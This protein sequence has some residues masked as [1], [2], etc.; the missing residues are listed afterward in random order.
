MSRQPSSDSCGFL[1][2][3]ERQ[4]LL[5]TELHKLGP[6]DQPAHLP[7]PYRFITIS[8]DA[9]SLGDQIASELGTRLGWSLYD[10]EI[11]DYIAHHSH[12]R[13]ALVDQMDEHARNRIHD[14]IRRFLQPFGND[15][16][17]VGMLKALVAL[18]AREHAIILGHGGAFAL[19]DQPGLH[20][21]V[22]ASLS[23][24]VG[25][26]ALDWGLPLEETRRRVV[27]VD[28]DRRSFI[29]FHFHED[30]EDTRF[31][32]VIF[33]TDHFAASQVVG[34]IVGIV[35]G[36]VPAETVREKG[37]ETARDDATTRHLA[38]AIAETL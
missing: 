19:R 29:R 21:R 10:K 31:Y 26:L 35:Q 18:A 4:M 20:I 15:E 23:Q 24:R 38:T 5:Q 25:R 27:R 16:Y 11:V 2:L 13:Q 8:R 34:A 33:N 7:G 3:V 36:G 37:F 9:G 14:T 6:R 28:A 32:H 30:R 22:T 17:H 1:H 12:V